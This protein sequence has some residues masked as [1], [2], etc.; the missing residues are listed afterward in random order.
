VSPI[1]LM[2]GARLIEIEQ[3]IGDYR[4]FFDDLMTRLAQVRIDVSHY[5]VSHLAFR[6]ETHDEYRELRGEIERAC[7]ANVENVWSGRPISKLLLRVPISLGRSH[8][9]DLIELIPP[10][11]R[12]G[13]PMG[14]EHVGFVV[15]D[16]IDSFA[17]QHRQVLTGRQDQG[18]FNQPLFVTFANSKSVKFHRYSLHDV[19]VMEGGNFNGF[20]HVDE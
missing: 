1:A 9:V 3:L 4:S 5:P 11:H 20:H 2:E 18:P 19:V 15:G 14:L 12:P 6:T 7:R 13:Y 17:E 8:A 10:D 16:N